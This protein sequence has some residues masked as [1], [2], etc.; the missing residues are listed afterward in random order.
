MP[1]RAQ[2][3][4]DAILGVSETVAAHGVDLVYAAR[5]DLDQR[6]GAAGRAKCLSEMRYHVAHLAESVLLCAP[7]LFTDYV[8]WAKV[9]LARRGVE[10]QD[11]VDTLAA[12][13]KAL[14]GALP[15][16]HFELADACVVAGLTALEAR[17]ADLPSGIVDD[18]PHAAL[19]RAFLDALLRGQ[20]Q[21][22]SKIVFDAL[23]AGV[24]VREIYLHVFQTTQREL[25]RLWQ[26]NRVSVAQEHYCTAA[27]QL[28]MSQLYPHIFTGARCGRTLVA[29]CVSSDLHEV[30]VRM[31]ADLF[32]LDGWDSYYLGASAPADSVVQT[33]IDRQADV[34]AASA[35]LTVHVPQVVE[36][37]TA[38]RAA[39]TRSDVI[40]LVGGYPFNLVPDLWREVGADGCAADAAA[41]PHLAAR[42]LAERRA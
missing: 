4:G 34:L 40:I 26:T 36:L 20:R 15:P 24:D 41:A 35:T 16:V 11:L 19:A 39:P 3:A 17:P 27:T 25:G 13:R 9:M 7:A 8:A 29:T 14:G 12:L 21:Q 23:A 28:I 18:Q 6:Y 32:E 30:G 31:V 10:A 33:V 38:M 2:A 1:Q 5:P 42:L 37:I 22:A